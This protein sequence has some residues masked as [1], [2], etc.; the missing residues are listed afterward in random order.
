MSY[1][2]ISIAAILRAIKYAPETKNGIC[3]QRLITHW[4]GPENCARM[5]EAM[6][7]WPKRSNCRVYPVPIRNET[8]SA[9][10]A[11]MAYM[12]ERENNR[13]LWDAS[14]EYGRLRW[15]LLDWLIKHP[16]LQNH[17]GSEDEKN[18]TELGSNYSP[19]A[20]VD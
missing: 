10:L 1:Q 6:C 3:A 9:A 15:E 2:K 13:S 11:Q 20:A 5:K 14:T 18:G 7:E 16:D 19:Q 12:R 17:S 8:P 4:L